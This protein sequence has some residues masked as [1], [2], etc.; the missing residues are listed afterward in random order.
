MVVIVIT[1]KPNHIF[2]C[3][4]GCMREISFRNWLSYRFANSVSFCI[5]SRSRSQQSYR[6]RAIT[7]KRLHLQS[8]ELISGTLY[9]IL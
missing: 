1:R 2:Y 5:P 3:A 4:Y 7:T 8:E 9:H 6:L